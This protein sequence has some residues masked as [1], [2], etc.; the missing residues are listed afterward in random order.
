MKRF[1]YIAL[2]LAIC[3]NSFAQKHVRLSFSASPSVNWMNTNSN[4]VDRRKSLLGYD[5]GLITDFYAAD[6][7]R[8]GLST[9]LLISNVGGQIAYSADRNFEFSG[10]TMPA[11]TSLKYRLK[12]VEVPLM[13]KLKTDMFKRYRYW[14]QFGF[15]G[16]I[17]I[18]ARGTS[19]NGLLDKS[20]I[21]DE[22]NLFNIAMNVG[23]GYDYDLGGNNALSVGLLF[24]NGLIDVTT[25][26]YFSDKTIVNSLKLKLGLIF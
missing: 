2:L 23:L 13:V 22:V 1:V 19:D 8:Y 15:S 4:E 7:E 14:G 25:D 12:Y 16:M 11:K 24:Q 9:G 26:N 17:N 6:D 20:N 3:L 21:N 10:V 18:E 5:F